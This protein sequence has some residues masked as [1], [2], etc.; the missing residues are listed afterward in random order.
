MSRSDASL[1]PHSV[2]LGTEEEM[3]TMN[4]L[5]ERSNVNLGEKPE[6]ESVTTVFGHPNLIFG[7]AYKKS[8]YMGF[9]QLHLNQAEIGSHLLWE[10]TGEFN[11]VINSL[12]YFHTTGV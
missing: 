8:S 2:I 11:S 4:F 1:K 7:I 5:G 12:N 10:R 9:T 3:V 6:S